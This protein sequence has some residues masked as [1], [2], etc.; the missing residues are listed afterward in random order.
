VFPHTEKLHVIERYT[1]IDIGHLD[2]RVTIDDPDTFVQPWGL[3][4]TWT[5]ALGHE[6]LE[7]ICAENNKF[8][9]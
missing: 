3:Q 7:Y 1:R 4:A 6:V 8:G 2:V 9:R 5:L